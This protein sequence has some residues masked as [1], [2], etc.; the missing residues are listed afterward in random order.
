MKPGSLRRRSDKREHHKLYE[1]W[2][3]CPQR[4]ECGRTCGWRPVGDPVE[5]PTMVRFGMTNGIVGR[6]RGYTRDG[7]DYLDHVGLIGLRHL[8]RNTSRRKTLDIEA[9]YIDHYRPPFNIQHNPDHDSAEQ[10]RDRLEI[11]GLDVP[12]QTQTEFYFE[13]AG[14]FASR[15]ALWVITSAL[16]A[17][18]MTVALA[19]L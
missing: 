7:T 2:T 17:A 8:P 4:C 11:L 13:R 12:W 3:G 18:A 14:W 16:G 9:G 15:F 6:L 1:Q 19:A 10:E 5:D